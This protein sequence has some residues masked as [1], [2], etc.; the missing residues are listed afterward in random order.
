MGA[1]VRG[2][3]SWVGREVTM[4]WEGW[5]KEKNMIRIQCIKINEKKWSSANTGKRN[6]VSC[7]HVSAHMHM[8][9]H[10]PEHKW[11]HTCLHEQSIQKSFITA[12]NSVPWTKEWFWVRCLHKFF[13]SLGHSGKRHLFL[14]F[15][16]TRHE[17]ERFHW[18]ASAKAERTW[19]GHQLRQSGPGNGHS[20]PD[21]CL[22]WILICRTQGKTG[23]MGSVLGHYSKHQDSSREC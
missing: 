8:H 2:G 11:K 19:E 16:L 1:R 23:N 22:L 4:I 3:R 6:I 21:T 7:G 20:C 18:W 12:K 9:I 15:S 14:L 10:T 5:E 17:E 13:G